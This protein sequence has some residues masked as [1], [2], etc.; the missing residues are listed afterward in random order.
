MDQLALIARTYPLY[1]N[2]YK[3]NLLEQEDHFEEALYHMQKCLL[4]NFNIFYNY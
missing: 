4:E 1:V 3:I 2:L